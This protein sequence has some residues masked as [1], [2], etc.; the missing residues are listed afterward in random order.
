MTITVLEEGQF[1]TSQS[2]RRL[3]PAEAEARQAQGALKALGLIEPNV[4]LAAQVK[5]LSTGSATA[6]YDTAGNEL[7]V[8]AG[9][10]TPFARKILVHELTNA[11]NDQH[12]ELDR[13]NLRSAGEAGD[14]F[15]AIAQ[16]V[17]ARVEERYMATM[18]ASEKQAVEAEQRRLAAL[19]PRDMPAVRPGV[20]RVPLHAPDCAWPT[21]WPWPVAGPPEYRPPVATGQHRAGAAPGEVRRRRGA[22]GRAR[23][24]R[25]T[26]RS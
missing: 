26:D 14:A 15:E 8:K 1:R 11:L 17:A 9:P 5:R 4:D 20:L 25:P 18:S 16:G 6:F 2:E 21:P 7:L 12:F 23:P 3:A 24:P 13:P 22:Q 10:A 19:I